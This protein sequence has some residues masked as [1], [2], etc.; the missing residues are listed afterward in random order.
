MRLDATTAEIIQFLQ[1]QGY[2]VHFPVEAEI[3]DEQARVSLGN[4]HAI[5][6][7]NAGGLHAEYDTGV[8]DPKGPTVDDE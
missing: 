2:R 6:T 1:R 7:R 8:N 3:G 4:R 5:V